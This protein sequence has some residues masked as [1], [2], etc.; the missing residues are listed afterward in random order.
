MPVRLKGCGPAHR[1]RQ[2]WA[3]SIPM[4]ASVTAAGP[5]RLDR[6]RRPCRRAGCR[7]DFI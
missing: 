5:D 3:C 4:S 7:A 6:S 1:H 2:V